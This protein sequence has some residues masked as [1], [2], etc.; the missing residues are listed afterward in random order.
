MKKNLIVLSI[1]AVFTFFNI[2]YVTGDKVLIGRLFPVS[3]GKLV[4]AIDETIPGY[5][6]LNGTPYGYQYEL[7][8]NYAAHIGKEL[9]VLS[10]SDMDYAVELMKHSQ[11]DM[12]ATTPGHVGADDGL[13]LLRP[14]YSSTYVVL[15]NKKAT[16]KLLKNTSVHKMFPAGSELIFQQGFIASKSYDQLLDSLREVN[17]FVSGRN[18][19]ELMSELNEAKTDYIIVEK[20]QA[21]M[22]CVMLR[23]IT[24]IY[25]FNEDIPL[26]LAV[27]RSNEKLAADFN[28]WLGE[29][30]ET[31]DYAVLY[32]LYYEK[33]IVK[34]IT[35][36]GYFVPLGNIS[37]FDDMIKETVRGT[38]HDWRLLS[39]IAY[40]ESRFNPYVVSR[41]GA[42]GLMQIM[43][44]VA[45]QF[46]V[47]DETIA[48]PKGNI[49]VAVKLLDRIERSLGF[50]GTISDYDRMCIILACYNAG[51]GHV[52][53]AR[54][55]AGKHGLNPDSWS[56]VAFFLVNKASEEYYDEQ[57]IKSGPL[58]GKETLA[59][60]NNVM[61][62]YMAYC[63]RSH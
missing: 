43:P 35:K 13:L 55:L 63:R 22:G 2:L 40:H 29:Y 57:L 12:V 4:V 62:R 1:I 51:I 3:N 48:D 31:D 23:N 41:R 33:D 26:V 32:S 5:F 58:K 19:F 47:P 49:Q 15:A 61:N 30:K 10:E 18:A 36:D 21:Q 20:L 14:E 42:M 44:S 28:K 25:D 16:R 39:A 9:V 53:D 7:L 45:R 17:M 54:R 27:E 11:I 24:E 37:P 38:N 6:V 34:R 56:D 50:N 8:N 59:F 60:V 46:D 52:I